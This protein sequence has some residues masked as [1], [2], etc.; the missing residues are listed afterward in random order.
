MKVA[1]VGLGQFG[2]ALARHLAR[3][4]A[5]VTAVDQDMKRVEEIKDDVALAVKLNAREED[6]LRSQ[7][8]DRADVVVAAIGD[9]FESDELVV[10]QAKRFGVKRV[11]GRASS[12]VHARILRLIGADEVVNPEEEAAERLAQRLL[13]PSLKNYF[14]LIEGYSVAE[15][16]APRSFLEKSIAELDLRGRLHVN[17]VAIKRELPTPAGE[18]PRETVDPVPSPSRK[19][20]AGDVLVLAGSDAAIQGVLREAQEG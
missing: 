5:E 20:R 13:H 17:L 8:I 10:V 11:I 2:A 4:G 15:V 3:H 18:S 7:G 6:E 16:D 12:P 14:E 9:D 1:V 19:F